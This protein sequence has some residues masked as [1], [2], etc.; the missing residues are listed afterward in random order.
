M[1]EFKILCPACTSILSSKK[2]IPGGK[3]IT[4]PHCQKQFVAATSVAAGSGP[5]SGG[6]VKSP[7]A[8]SDP[9]ASIAAGSPRNSPSSSLEFDFG[10][11]VVAPAPPPV[12]AN[13]TEMPAKTA[14]EPAPRAAAPAVRWTLIAGLMVFASV[15]SGLGVYLY[16]RWLEPPSV[17]R[18][19]EPKPIAVVQTKTKSE[20]RKESKGGKGVEPAANAKDDG[21]SP[22]TEEQNAEGA[23]KV[24]AK[25]AKAPTAKPPVKAAGPA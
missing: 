21:K 9:A 20:P 17:E 7:A 15:S 23:A 1:Q 3:K 13:K 5:A 22:E 16:M 18:K 25:P 8:K 11:T 24:Q 6:A 2:P 10:D 14:P 12:E 4:C 19:S